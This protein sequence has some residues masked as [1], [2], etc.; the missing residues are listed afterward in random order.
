MKFDYTFGNQAYKYDDDVGYQ[1]KKYKIMAPEQEQEIQPGREYLMNPKP[2]FDNPKYKGSDKLKGKVAI[3]TGG[4][5]GLGKA[6]AIAF[7]KEGAKVVIPYYNEHI[8]AKNTKDYIENMG[9]ECLFIAG[10]LTD[11]EFS[12]LIVKETLKKFGKI[13]ILVNNA[14]V[15]YQQDCLDNIS[16]EQFD[17][18]M[19]VNVYGMFYLTK[20]VL[21]YLKS[22]ASIINLSSITTFY[23]EPQ[24]IDYV[25]TKGA[26]VGFTRALARNLALKNIRVNAIAPGFFWTPLQPACWVKEKIPS[27]GAD[28]AMARGAMPYELAPT[29]VYLASDDSSYVT[30]QVLHNNG[31]QIMN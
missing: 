10:D 13:D 8:D 15:Q 4:D 17:Y 5:S 11:R 23:G 27:L 28:A 24:L 14:G 20:E 19:K 22:G 2:V 18:T 26:I 6:A 1:I 3:I 16:D 9:G 12:K 29:F 31:G 30:G 25:T 21:P 7:V